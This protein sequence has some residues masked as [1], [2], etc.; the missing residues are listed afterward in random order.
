MSPEMQMRARR[1]P[2]RYPSPEFPYVEVFFLLPCA[3][4]AIL[5]WQV[6]LTA[7]ILVLDILK[8]SGLLIWN[9]T[10]MLIYYGQRPNELM[11]KRVAMLGC[12][13][14]VL[15][16]SVKENKRLSSYAGLLVADDDP[17][18]HSA[19]RSLALL[20]GRVLVSLLFV[21]VG[22][23]QIK[24]VMLRDMALWKSEAR[25]GALIDGHDNNWLLLEFVLALPFAV[26]FKTE[27]VSRLLACTL[28]LEALTCWPFW[29][30]AWPTWHYAAHVR[31][32]FVT[33]LSVAGGLILLQGLGAGRY[34][35]DEVLKKKEFDSL[36]GRST[37]S[38]SKPPAVPSRQAE[39][40]YGPLPC[41]PC[42]PSEAINN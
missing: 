17:K 22:I 14:L 29:S 37:R 33:N 26:G 10:W 23:V 13:A 9:Q 27:T 18:R 36:P 16:H 19:G 41:P 31:S 15:V 12:S 25:R 7:S 24:R 40:V 42:K 6:P 5:G 35:V 4:L 30:S 34:T 39:A 21:Y 3:V 32:H 38:P 11:V 8:D 28:A 2:E 1:Y 20:L